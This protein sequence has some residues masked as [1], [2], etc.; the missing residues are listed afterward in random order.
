MSHPPPR[1]HNLFFD[2]NISLIREYYMNVNIF[3]FIFYIH[4][5]IHIYIDFLPE[6]SKQYT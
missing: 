2:K 3:T 1:K 6:V 4:I 5:Y